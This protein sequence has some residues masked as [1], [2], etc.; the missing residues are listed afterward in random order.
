LL[1]RGLQVQQV[2]VVTFTNAATAELRERVRSRIVETLAHLHDGDGAQSPGDLFVPHLVQA[3]EKRTG[4][5]RPE[6]ALTLD[7]ALQFFDEAAIFTIHGFCQRALADASFSA[8][9]PFSLELVTDDSE[10]AM[11]AV[12]DFWRRRIADE[13]CPPAL[14][15]YLRQRKD[16]PEK[17]AKLLGRSLA[18]PL[19]KCRWPVGIDTPAATTDMNA[20]TAAYET[21]RRIWAAECESIVAAVTAAIPAFWANVYTTDSISQALREWDAWFRKTSRLPASRDEQTKSAV[22]K[23]IGGAHQER[24]CHAHPPLLRLRRHSPRC[25]QRN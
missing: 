24:V 20:V 10:M 22:E 11:E 9:L 8:G 14:A 25:P 5:S 21:A 7:K 6:L 17:Y 19:A 18:K 23:R 1:E 16:A 2:L 12:H 3:V 13:G 15:A 4:S